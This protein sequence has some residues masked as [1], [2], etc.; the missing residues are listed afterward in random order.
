V[1][2]SQR[3][4]GVWDDAKF[5]ISGNGE[6]GLLRADEPNLRF[7]GLQ[8]NAH[9]GYALVA[10]QANNANSDI[11]LSHNII[12]GDQ[13]YLTNSRG[14][15]VDVSNNRLQ[16]VSIYN[17]IVYGYKYN[18]SF[19]SAGTSIL[20]SQISIYNNT[21]ALG[22]I[23]FHN[24]NFSSD[25]NLQLKNNLAYSNMTDFDFRNEGVVASHNFASDATASPNG[26][27]TDNA[28]FAFVNVSGNNY[29]LAGGD[30]GANGLGIDLS[31]DG[32]FSFS[33]D[34]DS[35]TR[36]IPWDVGADQN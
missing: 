33:D 23:G 14:I 29:K 10:N 27:G 9:I 3:H 18:I 32:T 8:I 36:A 4:N 16:N 21:T 22:Q 1:G 12:K 26:L 2:T 15:L 20:S 24:N 11:R 34:I 25:L 19:T 17:N 6:F 7:E 13:T 35:T 28:V 5:N 30:T 31:S